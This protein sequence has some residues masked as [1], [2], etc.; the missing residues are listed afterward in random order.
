MQSRLAYNFGHV[1]VLQKR[2]NNAMKVF[3]SLFTEQFKID[4]K[5]GHCFNCLERGGADFGDSISS[6]VKGLDVSFFII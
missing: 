2:R 5:L 4:T 6:G 1:N 3:Q